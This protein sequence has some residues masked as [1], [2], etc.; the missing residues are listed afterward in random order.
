MQKILHNILHKNV[1]NEKY[2]KKYAK[3]YISIKYFTLSRI[4]RKI[5]QNMQNM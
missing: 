1:K 2:A 4:L 5:L 3:Y